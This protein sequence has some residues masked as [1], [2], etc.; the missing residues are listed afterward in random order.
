MV[1]GRSLY[2]FVRH[3]VLCKGRG[4]AVVNHGRASESAIQVQKEIRPETCRSLGLLYCEV[5]WPSEAL[6]TTVL[7]G[8]NCTR[9]KRLKASTRKSNVALSKVIF[10]NTDKSKFAM[11]GWRKA[12]SVRDSLPK[13]KGAGAAKQARLKYGLLDPAIPRRFGMAPLVFFAHP[14]AAFGRR[15]P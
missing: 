12:L 3:R 4:P 14:E 9:L 2:S 1:K 6:F 7:G 8:P 11:P 13:V 5:I 10:L 15:V